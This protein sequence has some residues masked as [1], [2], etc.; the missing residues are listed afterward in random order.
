MLVDPATYMWT[1]KPQRYAIFLDL[2]CHIK[3]CWSL[4][5]CQIQQQYADAA[6]CTVAVK[7]VF[8][9]FKTDFVSNGINWLLK[10]SKFHP[11]F[12]LIWFD[13][14]IYW[15]RRYVIKVEDFLI[16]MHARFSCNCRFSLPAWKV[17]NSKFILKFELKFQQWDKLHIY[18]I[19]IW[20]STNWQIEYKEGSTSDGWQYQYVYSVSVE[21][22]NNTWEF[23]GIWPYLI[24]LSGHCS[25]KNKTMNQQRNI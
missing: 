17:M 24:L 6:H 22:D 12:I 5:H 16:N 4:N 9:I 3:I 15:I 19:H 18:Q 7:S 8:S 14:S 21:V 20:K 2:F 13:L 23:I 11:Y 25:S 1:P 10:D